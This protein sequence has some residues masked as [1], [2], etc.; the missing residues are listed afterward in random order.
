MS[1]PGDHA[2]DIWQAVALSADIGMRPKR[3]FF[4]GAPLVLFRSVQGIVALF[5]RCPHRLV[6]LS[7]GKVVGGEIE[8]PYHGWRYD[9][10]GR[11]TAIPG[12]VGAMPRYRV[13]R[14]AAIERDGVVFISSGAPQGEPYLH[15]MQGKDVIV[16]RVRSSTQSTVIDAAE[17][18]LDATHTHFTHKGLLR[19]LTSKRHLVRVEV[20]GGE[21]WVEACYTGEDRQQGLISR[22]LEGERAKTVGRFRHPGIAELEYWA[23][24][25]LVLAT[26][27]HLRQADEHTVEGVGWLI[28][29]RQGLLG[30]LKALAFKPLFNIALHQDRRVLKSASD[31]ARFA[32]QALPVIGPLD[33]LRRDIAAIME[34]KLPAAAGEPRVHQIEL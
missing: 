9:G 10:E 18:I 32:P 3:V 5:D 8:C 1:E 7:T 13:R 22:L 11:C 29:R 27:F 21:G 34:G 20:T 30:E 12:H 31:N 17:N 2:K 6:E 14:Y 26:T 33:F 25:G 15:C 23:K 4:E 19:G 24:H 16:R 28:G